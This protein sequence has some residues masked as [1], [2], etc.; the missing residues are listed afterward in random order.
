[1][2]PFWIVSS[3][4]SFHLERDF[5]PGVVYLDVE[6]N[7]ESFFVERRQVFGKHIHGMQLLLYASV[8]GYAFHAVVAYVPIMLGQ[9]DYIIFIIPGIPIVAESLFDYAAYKLVVYPIDIIVRLMTCF[10]YR[11][12]YRQSFLS[13]RFYT[14]NDIAKLSRWLTF[15][16]G[17]DE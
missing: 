14:I 3:V 12:I 6:I 10:Y 16:Y 7:E 15:R 13:E 1:M 5:D 11:I 8:I 9:I 4:I 17:K 2:F